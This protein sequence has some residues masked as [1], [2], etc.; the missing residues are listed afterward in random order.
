MESLVLL[1]ILGL[2]LITP[3]VDGFLNVYY[4]KADNNSICSH[5]PCKTLSEYTQNVS[6]YFTSDTQIVFLPGLHIYPESKH[7]HTYSECISTVTNR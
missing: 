3:D 2:S 7:I 1:S 4:V 6:A 5:N